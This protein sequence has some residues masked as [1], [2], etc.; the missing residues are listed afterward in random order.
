M[1]RIGL[2][3]AIHWRREVQLDA[4]P[5]GSWARRV[6]VLGKEMPIDE[7][8]VALLENSQQVDAVLALSRVAPTELETRLRAIIEPT[9]GNRLTEWWR[10]RVQRTTQPGADQPSPA[11][12]SAPAS[13]I[14]PSPLLRPA[15][16]DD[17]LDAWVVSDDQADQLE[18]WSTEAD[19]AP[20][21]PIE[22]VP[23][24]ANSAP[25][26]P[27]IEAA[28]PEH[29]RPGSLPG[30]RVA[31]LPA[32]AVLEV[33]IEVAAPDAV[34]ADAAAN[35]AVAAAQIDLPDELPEVVG[36]HPLDEEA[37]EAALQLF[38]SEAF[39]REPTSPGATPWWE[40]V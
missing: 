26:A 6:L 4:L 5:G 16:D 11:A 9:L 13:S 19:D 1:R 7:G 35:E 21:P 20:A 40:D 32:F 10:R 36:D 27:A 18:G 22:A 12:W 29:A 37:A 3:T 14:P 33:P 31:R 30:A 34:A 28:A 8:V 2:P 23:A 17:E 39:R 24:L 25:V 38:E 15:L